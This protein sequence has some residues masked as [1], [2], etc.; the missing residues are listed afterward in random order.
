[1]DCETIF[2]PKKRYALIVDKN[3]YK[4]ITFKCKRQPKRL[5]ENIASL[6]IVLLHNAY[7]R[8][9]KDINDIINTLIDYGIAQ[10]WYEYY[11]WHK[12]ELGLELNKKRGPQVFSLENVSYGFNVWMIACSVSVLGFVVELIQV[13]NKDKFE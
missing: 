10:H 7:G 12:Y 2:D 9:A 3:L 13:R 4:E 8:V 5:K 1:L 11:Q 6:S